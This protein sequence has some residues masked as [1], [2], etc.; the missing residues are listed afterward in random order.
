MPWVASAALLPVAWHRRRWSALPLLVP[1]LALAVLSFRVSRLD[2]F[3]T[4]TSVMLLAPCFAGLGPERLPL[5]RRPTR[6]ELAL[7]LAMFAIGAAAAG[8]AARGWAG[9]LTIPDP[10]GADD[11]AP[12]A[13]AV[14]FLRQNPLQGRL[15]TY[16]P[17]GEAAIW[18]LAPRLRVSYDGRRET[19]YSERVRAAHLAFYSDAPD[20]GYADRLHADFIWL[21]IRLRV[22]ERLERRGWVAIFRGEQ[23]VVLARRPGP[24]VQPPPWTGRRCF[25]GP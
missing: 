2:G 11:W 5:S 20:A 13:E 1:P 23:S 8:F 7:V 24:Y 25:P 6:T 14:T 10:T 15:L 21:P 16:F 22:V 19:V 9:C 18:H 12:E 3:F 17:Y 4:L